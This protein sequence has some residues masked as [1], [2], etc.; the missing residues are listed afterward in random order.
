MPHGYYTDTWRSAPAVGDIWMWTV[1]RLDCYSPST[2]RASLASSAKLCGMTQNA[3]SP[4]HVTGHVTRCEPSTPLASRRPRDLRASRT[5]ALSPR[6]QS[7][8]QFVGGRAS[9]SQSQFDPLSWPAANFCPQISTPCT[10]PLQRANPTC[11]C[12]LGMDS[13]SARAFSVRKQPRSCTKCQLSA[14]DFSTPC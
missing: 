6:W 4:C 9:S 14:I 1:W 5:S 2:S 13:R 11:L 10:L 3:A 12:L 8:Y 7:L